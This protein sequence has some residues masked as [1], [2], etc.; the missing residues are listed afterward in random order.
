M[1]VFTRLGYRSI[2]YFASIVFFFRF[3]GHFVCAMGN[4]ILNRISLSWDRV[5]LTIYHSG[6][7][8]VI[9]MVFI[10]SLMAT[11]MVLNIHYFLS[12]YRLEHQV[13][14][15]LQ[16][17]LTADL[18]PLFLAAV[19]LIQASLGMTTHYIKGLHRKPQETLEYYIIPIM[20]GLNAIGFMLYIYIYVVFHITC[21]IDFHYILKVDTHQ[22]LNRLANTF[23]FAL[24]L[25]SLFKTFVYVTI[26]SISLG[27]YYY[28]V[29]VHNISL[30]HALS[31]VISRGLLWLAVVSVFLKFNN[32]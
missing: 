25:Q 32:L 1:M 23:S 8:M 4:M 6:A 16:N 12:R 3:F 14:A 17:I 24:L 11:S 5:I 26:A 29:A 27:Y 20:V 19:L 9:P 28:C 10:S 22:Y 15:M 7:R 13:L 21:F 18:I 2:R 30:R 31:R